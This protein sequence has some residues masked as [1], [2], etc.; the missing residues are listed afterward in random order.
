MSF[1]DILLNQY[2][3]KNEWKINFVFQC[4]LIFKGIQ[5]IQHIYI[6]YKIINTQPDDIKN[7]C[8]FV[9]YIIILFKGGTLFE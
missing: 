6:K 3:N 1:L 7:I 5:V 2:W 4:I 9:C 8:L